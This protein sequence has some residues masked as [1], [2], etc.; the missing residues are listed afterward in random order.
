[1]AG[2]STTEGQLALSANGK[3]LTIAGYGVAPGQTSV[4]QTM[5]ATVN[6][7]VGRITISDGTIDT[8]TSLSDAYNSSAGANSNPRSAVTDDGTHFWT[9]GTAGTPDVASAGVRYTTLGS[10]TS[11]QLATTPTNTRVVNIQNVTG[12]NQLYLS[13]MSLA[14]RGVST[15]GTGLPSASGQTVSLLNG[16]DPSTTSPEDAYDFWFK[17]ANTLYIADE[18]LSNGAA[19]GL[20]GIQKWT[21]DGTTWTKAYTLNVDSPARG[22]SGTI[23]NGNAVLYAITTDTPTRLVTVTD[24]GAGSLYSTLTFADSNTAFRDVVFVPPAPAGVLGDYNGNGV[25]DAADYTVWRDHLGQT[26]A[27]PNRNPLLS[28]PIGMGDYT[29]WQSRYGAISGAGSLAGSAVPEPE[30]ICMLAMGAVWLA[31]SRR[32]RREQ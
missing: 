22:L 14:F 30:S 17:D 6:R 3:Y 12:S 21:S 25:V 11:T 27:L 20:G 19:T 32:T 9:T 29:Y 16:F 8:T 18:G 2:T 4:P 5:A 7:V 23:K 15:V 26:F 28:G 1:L 31:A 24:T 10:T 13:T